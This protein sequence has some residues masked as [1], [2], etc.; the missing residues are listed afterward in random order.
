MANQII[1]KPIGLIKNL[2]IHVH[3]IPYIIMFIVI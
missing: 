1:A 2:K 3:M